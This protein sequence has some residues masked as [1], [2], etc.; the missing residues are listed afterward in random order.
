[1]NNIGRSWSSEGETET[2]W[3]VT[4]Y[5]SVSFD[6]FKFYMPLI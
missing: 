3:S 6:T 4:K 5:K 1:M 2:N